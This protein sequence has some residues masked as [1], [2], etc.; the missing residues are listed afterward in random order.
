M[1]IHHLDVKIKS[2]IERRIETQVAG[3][4]KGCYKDPKD[5]CSIGDNPPITALTS[6]CG[7]RFMTVIFIHQAKAKLVT[8]S[9]QVSLDPK[10][11]NFVYKAKN[12]YKYISILLN[13][14]NRYENRPS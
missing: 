12:A 10:I 7:G 11:L 13:N 14:N 8:F 1:T 6:P 4:P 3:G 5:K 9:L 2:K